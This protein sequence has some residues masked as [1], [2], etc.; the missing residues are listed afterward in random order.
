MQPFETRPS[1]HV[2]LLHLLSLKIPLLYGRK[3]GGKIVK[4]RQKKEGEEKKV[5][6]ALLDRLRSIF[7]VIK[8]F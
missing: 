7:A 3:K 4:A 1:S 8:G 5:N 2:N 6:V